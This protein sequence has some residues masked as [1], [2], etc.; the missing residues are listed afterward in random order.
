MCLR[1][2]CDL[3][4]RACA[5]RCAV[6]ARHA[7]AKVPFSIKSFREHYARVRAMKVWVCLGTHK[8]THIIACLVLVCTQE[9]AQHGGTR[10]SGRKC[11]KIESKAAAGIHL[12]RK[13][14]CDAAE[15]RNFCRQDAFPG[16]EIIMYA[17]GL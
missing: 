8:H 12:K 15:E 1:V 5:L 6:L 10:Y 7:C 17:S 11:A 14:F 9:G 3:C 13:A 2:R 4:E 16:Q